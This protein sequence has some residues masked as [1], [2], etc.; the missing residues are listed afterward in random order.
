[1][2]FGEC[3]A[4]G[5]LEDAGDWCL[6]FLHLWKRAKRSPLPRVVFPLSQLLRE[7]T[8]GGAAVEERAVGEV[9]Q[10]R[11]K[12][13]LGVEALDDERVAGEE[14]KERDAVRAALAISAAPWYT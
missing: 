10:A 6:L 1:M 4:R 13:P 12:L 9:G 5:G 11:E 8:V 3:P 14:G 2:P 7:E